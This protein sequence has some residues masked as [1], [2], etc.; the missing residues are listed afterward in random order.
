[1]STNRFFQ[2]IAASL[3]CGAF[4][5]VSAF[6]QVPRPEAYQH[7]QAVEI[8]PSQAPQ[9]AGGF[10]NLQR[11][12]LRFGEKLPVQLRGPMKRVESVRYIPVRSKVKEIRL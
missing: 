2:L 5:A 3:M 7:L 8:Q 12:E 4:C 1:M 10:Q 6:A 9:L 11:R